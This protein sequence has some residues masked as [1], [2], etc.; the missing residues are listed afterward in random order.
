[1]ES[2]GVRLSSVS[3]GVAGQPHFRRNN[4]SFSLFFWLMT[5]SYLYIY[6]DIMHEAEHGLI[7][8][9]ECEWPAFLYPPGTS[10]DVEDDQLGLFRGYLL[11]R[12]SV[13]FFF[14]KAC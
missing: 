2:S 10:P 8:I 11:I 4:V 6:S 5:D 9:S 14:R 1:M 12:V 3:S 13:P 7:N